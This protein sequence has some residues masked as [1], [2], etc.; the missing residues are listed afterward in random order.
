MSLTLADVEKIAHLARLQLT[1]AEKIQYQGQL[2][3]VLDYVAQISELDLTDIA[4]TTHAVVQHNV[5]RDDVV[6][7]SMILADVLFNAPDQ[8]DNQFKIQAVLDE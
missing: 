3:S 1:A 6:E 2:S 4:P 8:A 7:P 5:L